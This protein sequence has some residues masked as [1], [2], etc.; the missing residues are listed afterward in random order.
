[1]SSP[2]LDIPPWQVGE[3]AIDFSAGIKPKQINRNVGPAKSSA[4][5]FHRLAFLP[6]SQRTAPLPWLDLDRGGA[7]L[8]SNCLKIPQVVVF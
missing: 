8:R 4:S 5:F 3:G 1:M 7:Q 6:P 2:D